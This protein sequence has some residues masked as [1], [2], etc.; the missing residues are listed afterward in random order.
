MGG[1]IFVLDMG[2]PIKI[3]DMARQMIEL[4][5]LKPDADIS[6]EFIGVRPGEKLFEEVTYQGES[7]VPTTHPKIRRFVSKPADLGEVRALLRGL[8]DNLHSLAPNQIKLL[9]RKGIPEYSP[10]QPPPDS[11]RTLV[12][13]S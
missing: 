11:F 8:H 4:S 9:L 12:H 5:G 2:E 1:E 13:L 10:S 6:I 3:V 7:F